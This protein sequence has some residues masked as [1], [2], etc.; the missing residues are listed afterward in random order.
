MAIYHGSA[1]LRN[2]GTDSITNKKDLNAGVS[3]PVKV[4]KYSD[5]TDATL[6]DI[7]DNPIANPVS[8][9]NKG[10][11]VF[12]A[13]DDE[14][15]IYF[16]KGTADEVKQERVQV[17]SLDSVA[18]L[19]VNETATLTDGQTVVTF[20]TENTTGASFHINGVGVDSRLLT[21]EDI[22]QMETTLTS[23][24]LF[25][26]YPAGTVITLSK[27]S[28]TG[29]TVDANIRREFVHNFATLADAVSSTKILAG[30]SVNLKERTTG[31]GGGAMWDVVLASS[32]T[33]NNDNIVACTGVATLALVYADGQSAHTI[34]STTQ[35]ET[36]DLPR[37]SVV[38]I[39]EDD[40]MKS[41]IYR[42]LSSA[43]YALLTPWRD[44]V[45]LDNGN[46]ARVDGSKKDKVA[47]LP[48]P[49]VIAH[50]GGVLVYPTHTLEAYRACVAAGV[51]AIEED[52]HPLLDGGLACHHDNTVDDSTDGTGNI[53]DFSTMGWQGLKVDAQNWF[54]GQVYSDLKTTLFSEVLSE[55]G[56]KV[57]HVPEV[58]GDSSGVKVVD[59]LVSNGM[60][61]ASI[62]QG[63]TLPQ[64]QAAIDA[65]IPA[66]IV[67]SAYTP[68]ELVTN[69]VEFVGLATTE[70][71]ATILSY[72]SA[73]VKVVMYTPNRHVDRTRFDALG[74]SGYFSDDPVYM[75]KSGYKLT[76][77]PFKNKTYYHGHL[78]N[79]FDIE[80]RGYFQNGGWGFPVSAVSKNF[81]L[82]GWGCPIEEDTYTIS[83]SIT[84]DDSAGG[85]DS[86]NIAFAAQTD[87]NFQDAA[88]STDAC[89][90]AIF[91]SSG[92]FI[93][94]RMEGS[95]YTSL[96]ATSMASIAQGDTIT[97]TIAVSPSQVVVTR[98]DI[99][100]SNQHSTN[101]TTYRG[102]YFH[103]GRN[104]AGVTFKD[105]TIT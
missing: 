62:V 94:Y 80:T 95:S 54:G 71:D 105:I 40:N 23:I 55:I 34:D 101:D 81:V 41:T 14:Y 2:D 87:D 39:K 90:H 42:I 19:T 104:T 5:D 93:L 21:S 51:V 92:L 83:G 47:E 56:D 44:D 60:E 6:Y 20:S 77:D 15:N 22:D 1:V 17:Y 79:N 35:L 82:Q 57:V 13:A 12:K 31:N 46:F 30:D 68:T 103:F 64:V 69:K 74:V 91:R 66:M 67:S 33:A 76:K 26:S 75:S 10:N 72:V 59:A 36:T 16:N 99:S 78:G 27:N 100:S 73:G 3:I 84:F 53:S 88:A 58:K 52:T 8:T 4:E 28:G 11:F 98:T 65:G 97:F 7:N 102:G 85:A 96:G 45:E 61:L 24:T 9:D 49:F 86:A 43:A 63:N 18:L 29:A 50:Q 70:S 89:Y 48:N 32:V 25:E 38:L 37:G